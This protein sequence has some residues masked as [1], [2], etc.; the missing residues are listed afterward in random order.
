MFESPIKTK[1]TEADL[2]IKIVCPSEKAGAL[3]AKIRNYFAYGTHEVWVLYSIQQELHQY[4]RGE[5]GSHIFTAEDSFISA[6]FPGLSI[7]IADLFL[8]PEA[9]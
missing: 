5:K 2:A 8:V 1:I 6:L 3:L 4:I 7:K 9:D